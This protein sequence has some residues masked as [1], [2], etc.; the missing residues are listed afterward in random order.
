[1][2]SDAADEQAISN[3]PELARLWR[4]TRSPAVEDRARAASQM[5]GF[6]HSSVFRRLSEMILDDPLSS[7]RL[8]GIAGLR[9]IV[10]GVLREDSSGERGPPPEPLGRVRPGRRRAPP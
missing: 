1:M 6:P 2:S 3:N 8:A 9:R 7:V 10:G 4:L 5:G